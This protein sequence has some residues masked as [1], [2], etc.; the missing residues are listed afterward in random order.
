MSRESNLSV[1]IA[2]LTDM[3]NADFISREEFTTLFNR[4]AKVLQLSTNELAGICT[5]SRPTVE[6]WLSGST[7]PHRVG[8]ASVFRVLLDTAKTQADNRP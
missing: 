5:A 6:R 2:D 8:R 1:L 3:A 7:T 4:A